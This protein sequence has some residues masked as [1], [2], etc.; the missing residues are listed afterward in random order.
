M[1]LKQAGIRAKDNFNDVQECHLS[2][3]LL[4]LA[5]ALEAKPSHGCYSIEQKNLSET[6]LSQWQMSGCLKAALMMQIAR[7]RVAL[8]HMIESDHE[9]MRKA[10]ALGI[11]PFPYDN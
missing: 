11:S 7:R 4:G 2:A 6:V 10:K 9:F 5:F 1:Q 8:K 3:L